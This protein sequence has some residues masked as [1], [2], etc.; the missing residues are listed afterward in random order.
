MKTTFARKGA[1]QSI[2]VTVA[3]SLASACQSAEPKAPAPSMDREQMAALHERVA[4][5]LRSEQPLDQCQEE[6]RKGCESMKGAACDM[7][8]MH[9][10]HG[11][12]GN[13]DAKGAGNS[14]Q[15][16]H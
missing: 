14:T 2:L 4:R 7:M 15:H 1:L 16:Q 3:F 10:M 9:G 12:M 8:A 11:A 6:M 5:C 13:K